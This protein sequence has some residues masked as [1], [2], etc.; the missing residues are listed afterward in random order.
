MIDN[1]RAAIGSLLVLLLFAACE[2][3]GPDN[4]RAFLDQLAAQEAVWAA[5]GP[6]SYTIEMTR[7]C[8]CPDSANVRLDVADD[9]ILSGVDVASGTALTEAE[10][11][12]QYT[13]VGLF[14]LVRDALNRGVPSLTISYDTDFGFVDLVY[15]D[16]DARRSTDDVLITVDDFVAGTDAP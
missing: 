11:E 5:A 4:R 1:R 9:V 15:I 16:Y 13:V 7:Q 8:N 3:T 12:G 14:D 2:T 6:S 10:L